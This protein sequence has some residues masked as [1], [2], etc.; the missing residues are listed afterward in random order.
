MRSHWH[1]D[2]EQWPTVPDLRD[3]FGAGEGSVKLGRPSSSYCIPGE[4]ALFFDGEEVREDTDGVGGSARSTSRGPCRVFTTVG[5]HST[6]LETRL[7]Y[8]PMLQEAK[9]T[10][11]GDYN[12]FDIAH[13]NI[14]FNENMWMSAGAPHVSVKCMTAILT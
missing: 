11:R 9:W 8:F 13:I 6:I 12:C 2:V 3:R 14:L 7:R 1:R 10:G 4:N 5:S